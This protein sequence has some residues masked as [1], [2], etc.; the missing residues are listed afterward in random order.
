MNIETEN[1]LFSLI[2]AIS[3]IG[4]IFFLIDGIIRFIMSL[5]LKFRKING[6][7]QIKRVLFCISPI[8]H[9]LCSH[10]EESTDKK[11]DP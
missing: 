3:I 8:L 6:S 10:Y 1:A 9:Y 11:N 5:I 2:N 7:F 4:M